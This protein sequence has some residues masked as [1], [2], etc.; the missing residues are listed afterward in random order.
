MN[1]PL[2]SLRQANSMITLSAKKL[3][4]YKGTVFTADFVKKR[5]NSY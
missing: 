2:Q 4:P 5:M 1:D 3:L